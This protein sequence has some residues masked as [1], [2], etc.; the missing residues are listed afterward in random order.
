VYKASTVYD[1]IGER[2]R[3]NHAIVVQAAW[4]AVVCGTMCLQ[5]SCKLLAYRKRLGWRH[6]SLYSTSTNTALDLLGV[7]STGTDCCLWT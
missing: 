3:S 6:S 7:G 1:K 2:Y 4:Q 5:A